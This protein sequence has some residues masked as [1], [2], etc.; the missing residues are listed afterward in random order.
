MVRKF[1]IV[2]LRHYN[3]LEYIIM[4]EQSQTDLYLYFYLYLFFMCYDRVIN[5]DIL[6]SFMVVLSSWIT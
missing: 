5:E 1:E 6:M 4:Y 2:N 3:Y